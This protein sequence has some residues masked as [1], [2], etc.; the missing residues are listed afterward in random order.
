MNV[1]IFPVIEL[2]SLSTWFNQYH[3]I[4]DGSV[5]VSIVQYAYSIC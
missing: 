2:C 5:F 1:Q 3:G 4:L